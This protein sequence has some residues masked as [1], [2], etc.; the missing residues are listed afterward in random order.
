MTTPAN[1]TTELIGRLRSQFSD[2]LIVPGDD[3]YDEA[4]TV[5]GGFDRRPGA[6]VRVAGESE[7]ARVVSFARETGT[8]LA[9]RGGGHS[10][11]GHGATDG[12]VVVDMSALRALDVDVDGRT[13][14]A[15]TG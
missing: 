12:G 4:R 7:V 1:S 3:R 5:F 15:Q 8:Q 6:I 2:R 10:P 13:A 11:V 9:I 14:W